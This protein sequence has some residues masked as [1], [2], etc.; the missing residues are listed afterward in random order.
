MKI[1]RGTNHDRAMTLLEV[2]I[3][4]AVV[5][6]FAAMLMPA[7]IKMKQHDQRIQCVNNMKQIGLAFRVWEG[8]HGGKYPMSVSETNGGSM[9]FIIGPNAWRH[10]QVF[11]NELGSPSHLICAAD[12][13][14]TA[15]SSFASLSNRNLSYFISVNVTNENDPDLIL[16]GD[17]N[18]T[19]GTPI[20]NGM[21]TLTTNSPAGWTSAMH[22]RSGHIGLADGSVELIGT[23]GLRAAIERE[24]NAPSRL[25][26]PVLGP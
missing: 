12:N 24:T 18:L 1:F 9:E 11:S 25:Q 26:M 5:G 2:I 19:N 15:A 7:L 6:I 22:V 3:V 16:S 10:F 23:A 20:T 8:N 4:I 13:S 17:R 14:R 21:L